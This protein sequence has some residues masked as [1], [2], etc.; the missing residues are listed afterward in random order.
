MGKKAGPVEQ[1]I[2]TGTSILIMLIQ[3][4]ACR[5][6]TKPSAHDFRLLRRGSPHD[7]QSFAGS[8][9]IQ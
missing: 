4:F 6:E 1:G 2:W 8:G 7:E 5:L 9:A 3:L